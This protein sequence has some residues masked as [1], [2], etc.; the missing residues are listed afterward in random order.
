MKHNIDDDND[1]DLDSKEQNQALTRVSLSR[2]KSRV[3]REISK[4]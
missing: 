2:E 1:D 3:E 4:I